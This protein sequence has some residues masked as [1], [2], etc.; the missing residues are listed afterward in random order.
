MSRCDA[1]AKATDKR[2]AILDATL[3]LLS[4][5]GFHGFSMKQLAE[6]A[7]VAA[8]T[9]YLYFEDRDDLI[10]KL[11][12][13]VVRE[14]AAH[15]FAGLDTRAPLAEQLRL[16]LRNLWQFGMTRPAAMLTKGQFDHLPPDILRS[17]RDAAHEV[18]LPFL[19]LLSTG[20]QSGEIKDLPDEV[21]VAL[22]FDPLCSMI[23]QH[24][25]DLLRISD[26]QFEQILDAT[27]DAISR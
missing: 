11:H 16:I 18:F 21:L 5:R 3:S 22:C 9:I 25:L 14:I 12:D 15:A 26:A 6:R 17:R 10:G 1:A 20:R 8:G 24:H 4:E 23:S 13:D 7:G 2:R 19:Q 27:W